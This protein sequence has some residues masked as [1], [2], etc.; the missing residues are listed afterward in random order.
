MKRTIYIFSDGELK[1]KDNT[2]FFETEEGKKYIP[3][4]NTSEIMVFGEVSLNKRFLEFLTQSEIILHFFNRYGYYVGSYYPREHLNSGYM[5]LKQAEHYNDVKK[6]L[7][8]AQKFVEGGYKNI[9]QVL[10]YYQNRGKNLEDIIYA[11]ERLGERIDST[12]SI[13]EVMALE[14]NIREYYYKG[15]DEVIQNP[16]FKFE[17]R[18]KRPPKNFLNALISFGNSLMYTVALSEIYKT[19]LDPRIGFLHTTNF[20]RFS[21]NLD[22]AEVF[23]PILVDRTIFTLL[24]KKMITSEDFEEEAEGLLIRD[25]AKKVFVQEFED[26]LQTTIKHR[27]LDNN[28][29]YRRLIRLELYKLEKH[30]IEEELYKPFVAQW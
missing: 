8:L 9:R 14:G 22:I 20:R 30:L 15:F 5:I 24:G 11:I 27:N 3:V 16:D 10:K 1:R 13:N 19:H 26:K 17:E 23:K 7:Y 2:L 6:R 4:E 21:L 12:S 28:V 25:N 29:S 18:T